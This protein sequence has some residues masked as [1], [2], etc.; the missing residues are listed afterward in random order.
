[1][2]WILNCT[3]PMGW[4]LRMTQFKEK[5]ARQREQVSTGLFDYPALMAAD[6]LLYRTDLVPVGEDQK[7]HVELTRDAAQR[8]NAIYGETLKLPEAVIP[9]RGARIMGLDDP[10]RKM[11]KTE[12]GQGHAIGL[13]DSADEIRRKIMR[14]TTD[15]LRE[16]RY[17]EARPG[18]S[19]L[20][21]IFELFT[22]TS[23][24]ELEKRYEG[25]GYAE[26]KKDLAEVVIEGLKPV[27]ARY[28]E[29]EGDPAYLDR[30][31][32]EG[33]AK[34]EPIAEDTLTMV[35]ERIGLA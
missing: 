26:F 15:S 9:E 20:L 24:G 31:L 25:K 10:T 27:Q 8:F 32:A 21:T 12:T 11:S 18:I 29:L 2:T 16:I 7:Q 22:A 34:V 1:M 14:A 23:R 13:L 19:N 5:S 3:I 33:R 28:R 35:K 17:D 4:M 6:I 30:L